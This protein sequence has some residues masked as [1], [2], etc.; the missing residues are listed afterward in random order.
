VIESLSDPLFDDYPPDYPLFADYPPDWTIPERDGKVAAV[1]FASVGWFVF[2]SGFLP[3][4]RRIARVIAGVAIQAPPPPVPEPVPEPLIPPRALAPPQD[5]APPQPL[6]PPRVLVPPLNV[7]PQNPAIDRPYESLRWLDDDKRQIGEIIT[8]MG[9]RSY[10][11]VL[12]C[13]FQFRGYEAEMDRGEPLHPY[14]F[15]ETIFGNPSLKQYMRTIIADPLLKIGFMSGVIKGMTRE[16]A[17]NNLDRYIEPF[18]QEMGVSPDLVRPLIRDRAWE[19]LVRH[20]I[21]NAVARG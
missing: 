5:F 12:T 2:C 10:M 9:T 21:D 1:F 11:Y 20:L 8:T 3:P 19:P 13:A 18:A 7:P 16:A 14:K 4:K 15:L 6:A 17:R